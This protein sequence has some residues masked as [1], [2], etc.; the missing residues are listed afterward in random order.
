MIIIIYKDH[1]Y[2][3]ITFKVI[4]LNDND[5]L[6]RLINLKNETFHILRYLMIIISS[7]FVKFVSCFSS[8]LQ[9][10]Q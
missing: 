8:E 10:I 7:S 9:I 4:S 1:F 6:Y 2:R 3:L 5:H